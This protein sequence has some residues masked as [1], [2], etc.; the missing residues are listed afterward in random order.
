[1]SLPSPNS[2]ENL[3]GYQRRLRIAVF[4]RNFSTTGG[5]AERYSI[6][7]VEQLAAKH[8]IHVFAQEITHNWPG[9]TYH[10]VSMPM[11]KP[12]WINQ[13]WFATCTWWLTGSGFDVVHSHENTWHGDVQTAHVLPVKYTLFS[14]LHGWRQVSRWI[15]VAT[16][17]RLLAYLGLE[18]L[19]FMYRP[20]RKVVVTSESLRKIME[21]TYPGC[22]RMMSVITPG[23]TLPPLLV[24]PLGKKNARSLL[25]LPQDGYC[26]LF[27]ANDYRKKGLNTLLKALSQCPAGFVLAVV[28][29]LSE[30]PI[31]MEQVKI[32]GLQC[33]VFFLGTLQN[34]APA[35]ESA[36]CLAHPTLEDTFGMAVLEAMSYG[37]PV[38]VSSSTYCGISGLL[39]HSA[40][41]LIIDDPLDPTELQHALEKALTQPLLNAEL[42]KGAIAFANCYQWTKLA[43]QQEMLYLDVDATKNG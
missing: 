12:R 19:R 24:T 28:G 15:K 43:L 9:V 20:N 32:L 4:N 18:H 8:D 17:P 2:A 42:S 31:F 34:V 29:N 36:D 41:A 37:L 26:I 33:R 6:A 7:L 25:G 3:I 35:Y 1:M 22:G 11:R 23:I 21:S 13:L 39:Q 10:R 16:S 14:E 27:V 30:L 38:I 5:G 40:N